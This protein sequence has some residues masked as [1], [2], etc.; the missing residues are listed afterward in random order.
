MRA[1]RRID[2]TA[3]HLFPTDY[4]ET[5]VCVDGMLVFAPEISPDQEAP[6]TIRTTTVSNAYAMAT[7]A[8]K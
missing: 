3:E 8:N 2:I 1:N 6:F 7:P 5:V 4:P